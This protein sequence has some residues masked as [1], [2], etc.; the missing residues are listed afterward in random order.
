M[1]FKAG[2]GGAPE[3]NDNRRKGKPLSDALRRVAAQRPEALRA[4][5]ERMFAM[6]IQ[7][8]MAAAKEIGDRLEG[9]AVAQVEQRVSGSI[10]IN[11]DDTKL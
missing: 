7:G 8:D 9:K 2:E 10:T 6:A 4:M 1:T 3:G 5:A 11:V